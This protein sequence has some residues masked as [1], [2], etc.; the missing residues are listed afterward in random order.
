M[1]LKLLLFIIVLF[2]SN[3]I[4]SQYISV[5]P[6]L[7]VRNDNLFALIGLVD[8]KIITFRNNDSK[9]ILNIFDNKLNRY[10]SRELLF[11]KKKIKIISIS[12]A[13]K[14]WVLIYSYLDKKN[15]IINAYR[16]NSVGNRIDSSQILV[17]KKKFPYKNYKNVESEDENQILLFKKLD[18]HL[19]QFI[20]VDLKTLKR[21]YFKTITFD[22]I[23]LNSEFRKVLIS[24]T[25]LFYTVFE[26][27]P[28]LFKKAKHRLIINAFNDENNNYITNKLKLNYNTTSIKVK[29]DNIN[30]TLNIAGINTKS[31]SD[32][33]PGYF[34]FKLK[35]NLD[36]INKL[37][38]K[39][40]NRFLNDFFNLKKKKQ[41]KNI[42]NII[43]KDILLRNDGG[44]IIVFEIK[45]ILSRHDNDM[46]HTRRSSSAFGSNTDYLFEDILLISLHEDGEEFWTKIIPKYQ[47]SSNDYGLYSSAFIFKTPSILKFIFNDEIRDENQIMM[48][49]INPLGESDRKSLFSTDLYNLN[50][51]FDKSVQISNSK[52]VVPSYKKDKLKLVMIE[53]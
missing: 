22:E 12:H 53:F 8:K 9:Y 29:F 15:E 28:S 30:N 27:K 34:I 26:T 44:T 7:D 6:E 39:Y 14:S 25:G 4:I 47:F 45:Q 16:Y 43:I 51:A 19:M 3:S 10:T 35:K 2:F 48:Y 1:K 23:N 38:K 32:K 40:S 33:S 49:S 50:L 52:L 18:K 11:E 36:I 31:T 20:R 5:A 24:N 46:Y 13:E 17:Q 41:K 42:R 37:D 21:T